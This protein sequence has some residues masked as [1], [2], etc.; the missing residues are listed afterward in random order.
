MTRRVVETKAVSA[1]RERLLVV[2]V[3]EEGINKE[4]IRRQNIYSKRHD[5]LVKSGSQYDFKD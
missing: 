4:F 3:Y 2:T 1:D 5:V